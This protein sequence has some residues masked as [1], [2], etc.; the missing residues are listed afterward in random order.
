MIKMLTALTVFCVCVAYLIGSINTAIIV[1]GFSGKDIRN[2]GSGNAGATNVLRNMGKGA[3]ALVA[4]F[5]AF[6]GVAAVL[7]AKYAPVIFKVDDPSMNAMFLSALA[8]VLGHIYPI[9]FGFKG[10]KG[11]ATSIAAIF[12]LDWEIGIILLV[13]C[14]AFMIITGYVSIGSCV[15]AVLFPVLVLMFHEDSKMFVF[16]SI[17]IGAIA[18]FKHR[19]NIKRLMAG[20]EPKLSFRR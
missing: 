1:S 13:T 20:T 12:V 19:T 17:A 11:I 18:L 8:V 4:F 6:K 3:A 16:V 14:L 9:Y 15:G 2:Y 10:G 5:D 7:L